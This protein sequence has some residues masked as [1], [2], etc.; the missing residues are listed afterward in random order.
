[1]QENNLCIITAIYPEALVMLRIL[2]FV[3]RILQEDPKELNKVKDCLKK[4][5]KDGHQ[6]FNF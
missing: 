4:A 3:K 6:D 5:K 2:K 1:L